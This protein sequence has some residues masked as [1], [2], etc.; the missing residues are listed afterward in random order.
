M[1]FKAPGEFTGGSNQR[2]TPED[3]ASETSFEGWVEFSKR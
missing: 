3:V 1:T 2:R